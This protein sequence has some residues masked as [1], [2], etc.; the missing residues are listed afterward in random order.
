MKIRIIAIVV[1]GLFSVTGCALQSPVPVAENFPLSLQKKVR[2]SH[3]W[4]VIADDVVSQT[5]KSLEAKDYLQGRAFF[6]RPVAQGKPTFDKAFRN[7][8]ITRMVNRGLPVSNSEAGSVEVQYET[9]VVQHQSDRPYYQPGAITVL[10][11]G[12]LVAR[13]LAVVEHS[14]QLVGGTLLGAAALADVAAGH[15][16]G[17]P[18][19]TEL[20]VTTSIV[21]DSRFVM[22]KSDVYYLED[23]DVGL[24]NETAEKEVVTKEWKVVGQ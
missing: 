2:A 21:V 7:F 1:G 22:R 14:A 15:A 19:K 24:F 5:L 12:V 8:M 17:G 10:T 23:L 9:Q 13:N 4:D 3:H 20:I 18:T 11:A 6:V 16:S